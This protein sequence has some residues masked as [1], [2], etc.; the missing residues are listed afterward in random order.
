MAAFSG[1]FMKALDLFPCTTTTIKMVSNVDTFCII[2]LFA[3]ALGAAW[4]IRS[5]ESPDSGVQWLLV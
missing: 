5:K 3:V 4:A 1:V 2:V